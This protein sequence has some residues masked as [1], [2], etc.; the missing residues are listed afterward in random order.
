ML[1]DRY[2]EL[3]TAYVDGELGARQRKAVLRLLHRSAEARAVLRQLQDDAAALRRLPRRRLG[4]EFPARVLQAVRDRRLQPGQP[5]LPRLQPRPVPAWVGVALAA[6]VLLLIGLGSYVYFARTPAEQPDNQSMVKIGNPRD[7][8]QHPQL[9][10]D[11]GTDATPGPKNDQQPPKESPPNEPPKASPA[12]V[13]VKPD[14]KAQTPPSPAN[15]PSPDAVLA[16]PVSNMEMFQPREAAVVLPVIFKTDDLDVAKLKDELKKDSGFRVEVPCRESVAALERLRAAFQANGFTL[17]IEQVAQA[18]LKQPKLHTNFVLY[19]ED[20]TPDELAKVLQLAASEDRKADAK[21]K[22]DG[23][24][25]G[26][27]LARMNKD[28]RK[29]LEVLGVPEK[30]AAKPGG[31]LGVD[32]RKPL[33]ETTGD[34]VAQALAGQGSTGRTDPGKPTV[35]GPERLVLVLPY[36]PDRPRPGSPE[37]KHFLD[38]RKPPRTGAIQ[39]LLVL[40]ETKG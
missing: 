21:K 31:P 5:S 14:D 30:A 3:L 12:D 18:R 8:D 35:K 34:Q 1:A 17:L 11:R 19:A 38:T 24:F 39:V 10:P 15:P 33:S 2:H 32:P 13:A 9:A 25:N 40:R 27:V 36:N 37:V 6:S 23:Q 22:G 26:L 4:E 16:Q 29:E 28:D 20:L 7:A